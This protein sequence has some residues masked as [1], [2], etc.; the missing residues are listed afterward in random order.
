MVGNDDYIYFIVTS[1]SCN[2]WIFSEMIILKN[3]FW[4][5]MI[6]SSSPGWEILK[7]KQALEWVYWEKYSEKF[8]FFNAPALSLIFPPQENINYEKLSIL[9]FQKFGDIELEDG[10]IAFNILK[11]IWYLQNDF[12]SEQWVQ[13]QDFDTLIA[14]IQKHQASF[15]QEVSDALSKVWLSTH[16]IWTQILEAHFLT[17]DLKVL[18]NSKPQTYG[19]LKRCFTWE[20]C[21]NIQDF[22]EEKKKLKVQIDAIHL[23]DF[24]LDENKRIQT[25][26]DYIELYYTILISIWDDHISKNKETYG[27]LI[28]ILK[29]YVLKETSQRSKKLEYSDFKNLYKKSLENEEIEKQLQFLAK[30][31]LSDIIETNQSETGWELLKSYILNMSF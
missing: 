11:N 17:Q 25:L 14:Y 18:A 23:Q 7:N 15:S 3:T 5:N 6:S 24:W 1:S 4:K 28:P 20:W 21:N 8:L 12:T 10:A 29:K 13:K 2:P 31:Y 9:L 19:N 26:E 16:F 30:N 27:K 22:I